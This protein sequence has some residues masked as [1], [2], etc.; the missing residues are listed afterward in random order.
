MSE[1]KLY[2]A[3]DGSLSIV[4]KTGG[5]THVYNSFVYEDTVYI[6]AGSDHFSYEETLSGLREEYGAP[7]IAVPVNLVP[8]FH[9]VAL[10]EAVRRDLKGTA[11][12]VYSTY[13]AAKIKGEV[14]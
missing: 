12:Y 6:I 2:N 3:V 7:V 11:E 14:A 9:G 1:S 13:M 4:R 10:A 8:K 5:M